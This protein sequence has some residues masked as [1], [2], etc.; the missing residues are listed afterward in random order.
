M[1]GFLTWFKGSTKLKRWIFL[2]LI[3]IILSCFGFA[4]IL[5]TD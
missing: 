2:I 1:K 3:G 5:V 4:N